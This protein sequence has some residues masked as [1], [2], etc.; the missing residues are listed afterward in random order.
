MLIERFAFVWIWQ[1]KIWFKNSPNSTIIGYD[2]DESSSQ[3]AWQT[4]LRL[5]FE[6]DQKSTQSYELHSFSKAALLFQVKTPGKADFLAKI[7][8][9]TGHWLKRFWFHFVH[10]KDDL[11]I[12]SIKNP[13]WIHSLIASRYATHSM[14]MTKRLVIKKCR[15]CHFPFFCH[16]N[17]FQLLLS[18][19][20]VFA[21]SSVGFRAFWRFSWKAKLG[22]AFLGGSWMTNPI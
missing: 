3:T 14:R 5:L 1:I 21:S 4:E 12:W 22:S 17:T 9:A 18:L 16:S 2:S 20:S 13:I 10:L 6:V 11:F 19:F 15:F 7:E 8:T